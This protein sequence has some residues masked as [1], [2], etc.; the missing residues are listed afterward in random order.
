MA[1]TEPDDV[2]K[3]SQCVAH[4][5]KHRTPHRARPVRMYHSWN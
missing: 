2:V 1:L 5:G 3:L 4:R